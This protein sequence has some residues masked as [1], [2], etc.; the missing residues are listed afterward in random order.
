MIQNLPA[1]AFPAPPLLDHAQYRSVI[2]KHE[3]EDE[4]FEYSGTNGFAARIE[5]VAPAGG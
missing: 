2:L 4:Q 5:A 1:P 3:A